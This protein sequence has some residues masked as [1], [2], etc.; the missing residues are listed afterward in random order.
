MGDD[1]EGH[2]VV[3]R[4]VLEERHQG[5]DPTG[6]RAYSYDRE[7]DRAP[8]EFGVAQGLREGAGHRESLFLGLYGGEVGWPREDTSGRPRAAAP[9]V[10]G[11]L[12]GWGCARAAPPRRARA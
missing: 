12:S 7:V 10:G 1:D 11:R 3:R 4:H 5:F 9:G 8:D 6:R 2:A